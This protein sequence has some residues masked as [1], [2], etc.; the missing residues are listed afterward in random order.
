MP[1]TPKSD[2]QK[3]KDVV[4][5]YKTEFEI[6]PNNL[7]YCKL[8]DI[9]VKHAKMYFIESHRK[10]GKHITH[11]KNSRN[12]LQPFIRLQNKDFA[13]Q[14]AQAFVSADIPLHKIRNPHIQRLFKDLG[15]P[16]PC[17][18]TCRSIVSEL[19]QSEIERIK[20]Y[21]ENK[22][23]FLIIDETDV[24]GNKYINILIG[25]ME[26]PQ[27][28]YLIVCIPI[29]GPANSQI[30]VH[31]IEDSINFMGI[32]RVNF[33]LLLSDCAPYMVAASKILHVLYPNLFHITCLAHLIHNCAMKVRMSYDNVDRL[34][35]CIKNAII[36]NKNRANDFINVGLPPTAIVTRWG[37]WINTALYYCQNL[38]EVIN[39]VSN[40]SGK[41]L[42]VKQA[43]DII[44][45]TNLLSSLIEIKECYSSLTRLV[46]TFENIRYTVKEAYDCIQNINFGH[47]PAQIK[48]YLS[49]RIS[50]N[51]IVDII[52]N[53]RIE[54]SPNSY[55]LLRNCQCTTLAVERS[56]S[57]LK[58]M[59]TKE[60]NFKAENIR[61]YLI[62]YHNSAID[63]NN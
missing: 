22:A 17:E 7:L 34:I 13:K 38:P 60:R 52:N 59:L 24:S 27:K 45:E 5:K 23:I 62:L 10:S 32:S 29:E 31:T 37:S 56:F 58:K 12:D 47:D 41:G 39:I 1:K 51:E 9:V 8:C 26:S 25:I 28:S 16:L 63:V 49:K 11:T 33:C 61:K 4:E 19:Y 36:K 14:I 15:K 53:S 21:V 6:T 43:Q 35:A 55:V 54:I 46:S 42:L 57:L 3:I 30:I 40:W 18:E 44:R 48:K 2:I 20:S 50:K